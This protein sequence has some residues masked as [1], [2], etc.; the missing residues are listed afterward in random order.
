MPDIK[1]RHIAGS[2]AALSPDTDI[3]AAYISVRPTRIERWTAT[4]AGIRDGRRGIVP[5]PETGLTPY[6]QA[7][8][9]HNAT[10][11]G[12]E[13]LR[14]QAQIAPID[15]S[16]AQWVER[17]ETAIHA[18]DSILDTHH[19]PTHPGDVAAIRQQRNHENQTKH[20]RDQIATTNEKISILDEQRADRINAG[21]LRIQRCIQRAQHL[22]AR[23]WRF[24]ARHH[25]E[26][27]ELRQV[28]AVPA[29]PVPPH[30][31]SL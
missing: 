1:N 12:S 22:V 11:I 4:L 15:Q 20:L 19:P 17:R 7:I 30:P 5:D 14:T 27:P 2:G 3:T 24:Y 23:Y 6:L 26:L 29:L 18:L 13:R 28:Y 16:R 31:L 9:A 10:A 8:A 21:A 25:P